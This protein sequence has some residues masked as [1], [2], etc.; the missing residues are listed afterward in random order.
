[1]GCR[2][3]LGWPDNLG[4]LLLNVDVLLRWRLLAWPDESGILR[5]STFS[6]LLEVVLVLAWGLLLLELGLELRLGRNWGDGHVAHIV[7]LR[8]HELL[9]G[10]YEWLLEV[11]LLVLV[12]LLLLWYG[13]SSPR[14]LRLIITHAWI[15][16]GSCSNTHMLPQISRRHALVWSFICK[17][18]IA[19]IS[20]LVHSHI[21]LWL[22]IEPCL[23]LRL[24]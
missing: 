12:K 8:W 1:M 13:W 20:S 7:G 4:L 16:I 5:G 11:Q 18:N 14:L 21:L 19:L 15:V 23:L 22:F 10:S 9:L 17:I 3:L 24:C 2:W 6:W